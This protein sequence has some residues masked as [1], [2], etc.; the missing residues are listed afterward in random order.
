MLVPLLVGAAAEGLSIGGTPVAAAIREETVT[1]SCLSEVVAAINDER[2]SEERG[3]ER[4]GD[5]VTSDDRETGGDKRDDFVTCG[6]DVDSEDSVK[7]RKTKKCRYIYY[8]GGERC[9]YN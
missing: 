5:L 4:T 3:G 2:I 7:K 1:S 9:K 8:R 6:V